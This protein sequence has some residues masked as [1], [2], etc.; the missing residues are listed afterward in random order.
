M[1]SRLLFTVDGTTSVAE[2][3]RTMCD[4]SIG[5]LGVR[6]G[7]GELAGLL[8]ERDVTWIA[9]Q[10]FDLSTTRVSEVLNDFPIVLDG[11]ISPA[12]AASRMRDAHVRHLL[13]REDGE[14]RI[15]SLRDVVDAQP[16]AP[17]YASDAMSSPAVACHENAH[18]EDVAEVLAERRLSGLPVVDDSGCVTG[19]ISERDLAHAYGGPLIRFVLRRGEHEVQAPAAEPQRV[20]DLMSTPPLTVT[21]DTELDDVASLM[22]DHTVNRIP[23]LDDGVLVGVLTRGDVLAAYAGRRR[24]TVVSPPVVIGRTEFAVR[25]A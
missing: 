5:A 20:R 2:A 22:T 11:P 13:L 7:A 4:R 12:T 3:A 18:L 24:T 6:G 17:S 15:V 14:L 25:P 10:G 19:V 1:E 9:A 23:V 16:A 21:V 8:T